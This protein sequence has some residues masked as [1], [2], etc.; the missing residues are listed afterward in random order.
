MVTIARQHQGDT[1]ASYVKRGS[2]R[3]ARCPRN[4]AADSAGHCALEDVNKVMN[5]HVY[6]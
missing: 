6:I 4:R 3:S 2:G 1:C 5:V